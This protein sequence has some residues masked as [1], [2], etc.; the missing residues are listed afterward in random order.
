VYLFLEKNNE[1]FIKININFFPGENKKILLEEEFALK[2]EISSNEEW[3]KPEQEIRTVKIEKEIDEN[4]EIWKLKTI[5]S[6]R[7]TN[8][9]IRL[10]QEREFDW[11]KIIE[12]KIKSEIF[13]FVEKNEANFKEK[14]KTFII[15]DTDSGYNITKDVVKWT[16]EE[17]ELIE[18]IIE[19]KNKENWLE[20]Q[21]K[22][23]ELK[24][25]V[26]P[27]AIA[28]RLF[29]IGIFLLNLNNG[30]IAISCLLV[31]SIV[32]IVDYVRNSKTAKKMIELK[33]EKI[34]EI[35][36]KGFSLKLEEEIDNI[37]EGE[38]K[39]LKI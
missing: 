6:E 4:T 35:E 8:I 16:Q 2:I 36:T 29:I 17:K 13:D 7:K 19:N 25:T 20:A 26:R 9:H 33:R 38:I 23:I 27:F 15:F 3:I 31:L 32:L 1:K 37:L 12:Q 34:K 28:Y 11:E 21:I 22:K 30:K 18:E 24:L 14:E 39:K 5:D 10:S